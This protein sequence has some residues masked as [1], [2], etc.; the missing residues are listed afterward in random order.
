MGRQFIPADIND[1]LISK[2][3]RYRMMYS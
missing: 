1:R 3:W 2:C